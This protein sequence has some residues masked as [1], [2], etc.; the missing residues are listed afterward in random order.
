M[1]CRAINALPD[2]LVFFD[3]RP[4]KTAEDWSARRTEIL[5]LYAKWVWGKMPPLPKL[6]HA[7][8]HDEPATGYRTRTG[9]LFCGPGGRASIRVT[10][11]IP[12]GAGPFPVVMGPGLIRAFGITPGAVRRGSAAAPARG[13]AS[14]VIRR[15]GYIVCSIAANDGNDDSI[16]LAAL[17]PE[18]DPGALVR[19]GW[20]ASA[21]VD[22][23]VTL[24]EVDSQ[25]IAITGYSRDG[26]AMAIGAASMNGLPR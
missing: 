15:H 9:N 7:D 11:Q 12:D 24:P 6:D 13:G 3:G 22:Y 8:V 2:P 16:K 18:C 17:Y 10:M 25:H 14:E 5:D 21:V 4:V 26:K 1:H 20:A 19:R 23:L